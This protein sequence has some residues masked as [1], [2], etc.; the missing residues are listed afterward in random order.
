[1]RRRVQFINPAAR[2]HAHFRFPKATVTGGN[3]VTAAAV[4]VKTDDKF[5]MLQ[6]LMD[7]V[8]SMCG[9]VLYGRAKLD[10]PSSRKKQPL[11][12]LAAASHYVT[13]NTLTS[14]LKNSANS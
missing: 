2:R 13:A 8:L 14:D 11:C 7:S 10:R 1:M 3:V 6:R 9:G 5:V 12:F 4:A